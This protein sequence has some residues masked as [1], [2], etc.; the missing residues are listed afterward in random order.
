MMSSLRKGIFSLAHDFNRGKISQK[1]YIPKGF[2]R[3]GSAITRL[4]HFGVGSIIIFILFMSVMLN[5]KV[6]AQ[7]VRP[8]RDNVGFC[9]SASE[10]DNV[11]SFLDKNDNA[12]KSFPSRNLVAAISPHDDYLY[13]G[14]IYYPLFKLIHA[15][16]IVIFGVTHGTVRKAMDDP[17]N[18]LIFDKFDK[19]KGPYGNVEISPLRE[20][21]K[22]NLPKSEFIISNKAQKIEHSI[23][24][25]IPFLQHYNRNIKITPVMVTEMPYSRMDSV[26]S[27]FAEIVEKYI[28][29]NNLKLGKDIFFLISSDANHY[30]EDF[31]NS[32]YGLDKKAHKSATDRD[33]Q[34][35]GNH[36]NCEITTADIKDLSRQIWDSNNKKKIIPLWCG[37]YP[38]IFGL[39]T[40]DKIVHK[41][42]GEKLEGKLFKY[43]DT[44]TE[45]VLPIKGTHLGTTAPVSY[46]HWVGFLSAGFYI[47]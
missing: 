23:E 47:K 14:R 24:A 36:F 41:L 20:I 44:K 8:I 6:N 40:V 37:R 4:V 42:N 17:K 38:I 10:M 11:I 13:A 15:K 30:G 19:W 29:K 34:I 1:R 45:G 16:E 9:W 3:Y 28:S 35:A 46:K 25:M 12:E 18:I 32:P 5:R 39:S 27:N 21:L 43:S 33:K 31:S 7:S 2:F 26:S 22:N